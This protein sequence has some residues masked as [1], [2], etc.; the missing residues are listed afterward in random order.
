MAVIFILFNSNY[1]IKNFNVKGNKYFQC[2]LCDCKYNKKR[3][4][5]KKDYK[6]TDDVYICIV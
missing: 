4:I 2:Y 5:H 1:I 3:L 6:K